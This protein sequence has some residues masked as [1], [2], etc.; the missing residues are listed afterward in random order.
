MLEWK[1]ISVGVRPVPSPAATPWVWAVTAIAALV[2]VAAF[3]LVAGT[4]NP[5]P[6]LIALSLTVAMVST[7]ARLAAAPGTALLCWLVLNAFATA[8]M[9]EIT[10]ETRHDLGRLTCLFLAASAG[11]ATARLAHA[12][13][14]YHRL[15]P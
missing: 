8:P 5:T 15:T 6:A 13:A 7:A 11:T 3:N 9:G 10:W 1:W 14:A 2:L 4:G 12:R